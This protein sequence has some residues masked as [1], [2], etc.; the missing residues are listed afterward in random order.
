MNSYVVR[1]YRRNEV[2]PGD[3]TGL[4]EEPLTGRTAPFRNAEELWL[5]VGAPAAGS[6]DQCSI[7]ASVS[8]LGE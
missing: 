3:V 6:N 4:V 7:K 2:A 5:I 1:V 8:L